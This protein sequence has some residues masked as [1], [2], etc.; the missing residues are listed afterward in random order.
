MLGFFLLKGNGTKHF[1]DDHKEKLFIK[2]VGYLAEIWKSLNHR[3]NMKVDL[4][5]LFG[6]HVT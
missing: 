2:Q 5:S 4:Q 6:L 3:L 1:C